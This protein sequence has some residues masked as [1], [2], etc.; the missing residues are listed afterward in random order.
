MSSGYVHWW[1]GFVS[2]VRVYS[3]DPAGSIVPAG[4]LGL[5]DVYIKQ[6]DGYW[7]WYYRPWVRRSVMATD[8]GGN[9]YLYAVSDVGIRV[10]QLGHLDQP[11]ATVLFNKA[12]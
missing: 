9:T 11:L 8:Q 5:S 12:H 7:S 4:R 1:D 6:S 10:G 3:V 2:D